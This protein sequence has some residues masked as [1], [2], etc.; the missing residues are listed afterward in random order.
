MIV[1]EE[2]VQEIVERFSACEYCG[3]KVKIGPAEDATT[4][5]PKCGAKRHE[6][7]EKRQIKKQVPVKK[8]DPP[9]Q[10][11]PLKGGFAWNGL[12]K[13]LLFIIVVILIGSIVYVISAMK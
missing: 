9:K 7:I 12:G 1:N 10:P 13:I 5:C 2:I 4:L 6:V 3:T 11:E 8:E